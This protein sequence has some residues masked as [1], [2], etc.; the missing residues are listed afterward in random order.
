MRTNKMKI[1]KDLIKG[2]VVEALQDKKAVINENKISK[3][4]LKQIIKEEYTRLLKE[5]HWDPKPGREPA[6]DRPHEYWRGFER[7]NLGGHNVSPY[8][9]E[10]DTEPRPNK[11][12]EEMLSDAQ[13]MLIDL[14]RF[15]NKE[16]DK[17]TGIRAEGFGEFFTQ[18]KK[19]FIENLYN[20][21][22]TEIKQKK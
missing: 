20:K 9:V 10:P 12:Y 21:L 1:T 19:D 7:P 11:K 4:T 8:D 6:G 13:G 18:E 22:S 15:N 5:A 17:L 3:N 16:Y 14:G 2:L